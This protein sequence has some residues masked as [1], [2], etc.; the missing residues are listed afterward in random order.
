MSL[1]SG[2]VV[3]ALNGL[4]ESVVKAGIGSPWAIGGGVV[5]L[6]MT[7]AETGRRRQVPVAGARWG[8]RLM[9]STVRSD[10]HWLHNV[11]ENPSV[12]VW[13][14]GRRRSAVARVNRGPINVVT[15]ELADD[16]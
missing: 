15:L 8:D 7:G 10:S 2:S 9:I 11:E 1:L 3:S 13:L 16:G 4:V 6:E 14:G 12:R 5:V